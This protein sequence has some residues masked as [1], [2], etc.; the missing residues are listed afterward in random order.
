MTDVNMQQAEQ[1]E[2]HLWAHAASDKTGQTFMSLLQ[3]ADKERNFWGGYGIVGGHTTL[4]VGAAF[5]SKYTEDNGVSLVYF[6]DGA[7]QQGA[8]FESMLLAQLWKLPVV[9]IIENNHYAMGT[10]VERHAS[11][12]ELYKRGISFEIEGEEVDGMDVYAV[13]KAGE[14]AVKHA[15]SGK[16]P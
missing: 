7:A 6:G 4:A 15:R 14:K 12:T 9:F 1:D 16:G 3:L 11:E 10:S 8:F 13:K 5:A 2:D